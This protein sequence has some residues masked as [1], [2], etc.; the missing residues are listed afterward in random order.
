MNYFELYPGDY[1]RDTAA[2]T[3]AQHGAFLLLLMTYY[4]TEKPIPNDNPTLFRIAR[5]MTPD[6]QSAVIVVADMFFPVSQVDGLRHNDRA[7]SDI[8]KARIRIESARSNGGKGGRPK[9]PD[10]NPL[11][12]DPVKRNET[13]DVT[14]SKAPHTPDPI[15]HKEQ[16]QKQK[17]GKPPALTLPDW[18]TESAWAD[19]H[20]FR[21]QRKGW[22][23]KARE[24][25]L[26]TLTKLRTKGHDPTAVIEQSIERG[27]TGLFEIKPETRN[28]NIQPSR[29]LSAVERIEQNIHAGRAERAAQAS[30]GSDD[31]AGMDADGE[32]IRQRLGESVQ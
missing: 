3:L 14:G 9:K 8:A 6:E 30:I 12:S 21:N 16:D 19:W 32:P 22:T 5:A 10:G 27:W 28:A 20:T 15:H 1:Q 29:K 13:Q 26:A 24:L 7:E 18:L 11:G 17:G 23:Y 31:R 4:S 25:S 2:L